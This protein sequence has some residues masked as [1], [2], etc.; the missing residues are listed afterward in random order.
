MVLVMVGMNHDRD[1]QEDDRD[2]PSVQEV[3]TVQPFHIILQ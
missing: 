1:D 2:R 3:A